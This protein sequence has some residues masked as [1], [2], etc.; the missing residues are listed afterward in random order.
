MNSF[1]KTLIFRIL[2]YSGLFLLC[3]WLNRKKIPILMYHGISPQDSPEWTQLSLHKFQQQ[4]QH[5]Y[6]YYNAI[7]L[8][9]AIGH[10]R[11]H[12]QIPDKAVVITFDDGYRSNFTL[13]KSVLD[14][15]KI[16][17]TVFVTTA[18]I[19]SDEEQP[20]FLWFDQIY[21][22]FL[23][24][25]E[26]SIDLNMIQLGILTFS[27]QIEKN[28]AAEKVN[29]QLKKYPVNEKNAL[30]KDIVRKLNPRMDNNPC[31]QGASWSEIKQ[32]FPRITVGAHTVNHEILTQLP[33]TQAVKEI[34]DSKCIIEKSI[35]HPVTLFAYPNGRKE[36]FNSTIIDTVKK[37][38]YDGA[39]TTIEGLNERDDDVYQLKRIAISSDIDYIH[40][41][42][43]VSGTIDC[44]RKIIGR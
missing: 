4:M 21:H 18:F 2:Y 36:D 34:E 37:A 15:F 43:L 19:C 7:P 44:V 42:L 1:F 27:T 39:V 26:L 32:A 30:V 28:M 14:E 40:F 20:L 33:I 3:R 41:R 38:Q 5:L 8:S 10:I 11:D 22:A 25:Q 12:K 24:S 17:A 16:P 13:A 35:G 31:Y 6:R 9:E 29:N 23:N